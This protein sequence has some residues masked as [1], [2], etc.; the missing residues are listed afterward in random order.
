MKKFKLGLLG[1]VL[2]TSSILV[3]CE[4][5]TES[6]QDKLLKET[7]NK[8]DQSVKV[9]E[10]VKAPT[11]T[12]SVERENIAKRIETTNDANLLQWIYPMSA[13]RVIGRFP[14]RGK[15]T[16]GDKRLASTEMLND[17]G[18]SGG[19]SATHVVEAPDEMGAY[20]SSGGYVFWFSPSGQYHQHKGDYFLSTEPYKLDLGN[21]TI[22]IDLDE[23]ELKKISEYD[24]QS[25]ANGEGK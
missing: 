9:M 5:G 1:T 7:Q 12:Y 14:V 4:E 11:I 24:K 20:G 2:L 10:S 8:L 18:R 25:K 19:Y 23:N 13:G 22:S 6:S 21:G 15:V 3:A 17:N 16:S